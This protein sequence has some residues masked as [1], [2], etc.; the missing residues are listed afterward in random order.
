M[1]ETLNAV[2]RTDFVAFAQKVFATVYP[3]KTYLHNWHIEAIAYVLER[4]LSGDL[5]RLIITQ[6]P[7]SLKSLFASVVLPAWAL[8][9]DPSL[10]FACVSYAGDLATDFARQFRMVVKSPWYRA[11]FP[12]MQLTRATETDCTTTLGGGRL[13]VSVG[14]TITGRG[15]DMIVVDDALKAEDAQSEAVRRA[16]N[17]W[18]GGTLLSRL[19][20]KRSG[21][22]IV[23]MQRL[24]EE[25]L[26]GTLLAAGGWHHLDLPAIALCDE[27][28]PIGHGR[29]HRRREGD[30]LHPER[31]PLLELERQRRDMAAS[32]SRLNI[33]NA[34]FRRRAILSSG[35]GSRATK[36]HPKRSLE[37]R[38]FRAGTSRAAPMETPTIPFAP[39][40]SSS[41]GTATSSTFGASTETSQP[42]AA[43]S[44]ALL[45]LIK[46]TLC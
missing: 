20:D 5:C 34:Q 22:I 14:G 12:R 21:R 16:T 24:H 38:L 3:G 43:R 39:P 30:V 4:A 6:P 7:R 27:Q 46:P 13:A 11:A 28:I 42:F 29:V 36:C 10:R 31:E 2:L 17:N 19:N 25:D 41:S 37:R 8:G 40:G 44:S 15:A 1:Q 9:H 26:A 18:F 33:N 45:N 35:S 23:V 32:S